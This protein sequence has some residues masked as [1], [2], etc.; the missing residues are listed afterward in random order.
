MRAFVAL[1]VQQRVAVVYGRGSFRAQWNLHRLA[2]TGYQEPVIHGGGAGLTHL[3]W[4]TVRSWGARVSS[5]S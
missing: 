2:V 4:Y 5:G 1:N 3:T